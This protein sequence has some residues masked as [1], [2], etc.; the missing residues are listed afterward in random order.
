MIFPEEFVNCGGAANLKIRKERPKGPIYLQH[1][2]GECLYLT[3]T[4]I[5]SPLNIPV[6]E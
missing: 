2:A 1:S 4:Q 6:I 3:N 5:Y